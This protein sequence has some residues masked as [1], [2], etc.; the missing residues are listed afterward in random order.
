[1]F[2]TVPFTSAAGTGVDVRDETRFAG[3]DGPSARIRAFRG[4]DVTG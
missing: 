2:H 3:A 1:M 4:I